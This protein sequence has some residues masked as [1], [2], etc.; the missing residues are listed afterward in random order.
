MGLSVW[1][2]INT[3]L[4]ILHIVFLILLTIFVSNYVSCSTDFLAA[5]Y[6]CVCKPHRSFSRRANIKKTLNLSFLGC[7]AILTQYSLTQSVVV[8]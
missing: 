5:F 7:N 1:H 4:I 8:W 2:Q 3:Y 6:Y